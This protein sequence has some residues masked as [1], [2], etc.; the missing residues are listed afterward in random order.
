MTTAPERCGAAPFAQILHGTQS[1]ERPRYTTQSSPTETDRGASAENAVHDERPQAKEAEASSN[2]ATS[3]A[4][5]CKDTAA[6]SSSSCSRLV[7]AARGAAIL[8]SAI[9]QASATVTGGTPWAAAT[10]VRAS[11]TLR[12]SGVRKRL[13]APPRARPS[14][15]CSL[16]YLPVR[17][18]PAI[19]WYGNTDMPWR[20]AA[21]A[22]SFSYPRATSEYCGWSATG[23]AKPFS[24]ATRNH[25]SIAS[26]EKLDNAMAR[27]LPWVMSSSK[28][29][30]LST[31]GV[32]SSW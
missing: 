25:S 28:A 17:K 9:A 12:P 20:R 24:S 8:P 5:S 18:P 11:T 29:A 10:S 19:T 27:T 7:A 4:P 15:S 14:A 31:I 16:R 3:S 23:L 32:S 22:S 1:N 13:T 6:S 30:A 21:G 2:A 26:A